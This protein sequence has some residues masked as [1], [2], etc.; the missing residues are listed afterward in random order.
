[1]IAMQTMNALRV[2]RLRR[3]DVPK[4]Q[5]EITLCQSYHNIYEVNS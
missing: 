4:A 5:F 2:M 1:M 3:Y